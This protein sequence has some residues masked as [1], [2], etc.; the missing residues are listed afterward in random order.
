MIGVYVPGVPES[1]A[2]LTAFTKSTGVQPRLVMYFSGWKEQFQRKFADAVSAAG[3]VP[4]VQIET[5]NLPLARIS[6][7]EQDGYLVRFAQQ[8]KSYARPVVVSFD[9]EMNGTWYKWGWKNV[10][11]DQYIGAYRHIVDVFRLLG[12]SNVTWMWTVNAYA[13]APTLISPATEWWPGNAYVGWVGIDG[14]FLTA[15][16]NFTGLFQPVINDIR[17]VTNKPILLA[18]TAIALS[19]GQTALMGDLFAGVQSDGLLGLVWFDAKGNQDF[20][21]ASSASIAA[22]E[23][24]VKEYGYAQ[25][26]AVAG[27]PRLVRSYARPAHQEV[28]VQVMT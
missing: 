18:E 19:A 23:H 10:T 4:L 5:G 2:A 27:A 1:A 22:F 12:V 9:H 3:G 8:I 15:S 13:D 25:G 26:A 7:G 11:P 6:A 24:A 21:L 28:I 14:H 17:T 20:R 16:E